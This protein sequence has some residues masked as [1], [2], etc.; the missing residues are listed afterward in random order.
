MEDR[1]K[2]KN[3]LIAEAQA[4]ADKYNEKKSVI[5]AALDDLDSKKVIGEEHLRGMSIIE[6]MFNELD[7]IEVEQLEIF[8]NIKKM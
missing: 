7:K 1:R 4:L 2:N 8:K 3:E 5:E 6:E